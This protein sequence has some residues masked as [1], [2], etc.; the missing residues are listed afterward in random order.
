MAA[1]YSPFI[2]AY[3]HLEEFLTYRGYDK[4]F[5]A[6]RPSHVQDSDLNGQLTP[7]AVVK[8][9]SDKLGEWEILASRKNGN[10]K[11]EVAIVF[12]LNETGKYSK[13]AQDFR[14]LVSSSSQKVDAYGK[15]IGEAVIHTETIVLTPEDVSKKQHLQAA[16]K[17]LN[18]MPGNTL[19]CMYPFYIFLSNIPEVPCVPKHELI[20]AEMGELFL[21]LFFLTRQQ[22]PRIS[23]T[24]PPVVWLGGRPGDFVV[25]WRPSET[26]A[27]L[28]PVLRYVS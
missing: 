8:N 11:T 28:F 10:G 27:T 15:S 16:L 2:G 20:P 1:Y 4:I 24:D 13:Q 21:T 3:L 5:E 12:L 25:V 14:R 7:I 17:E 19:Y 23:V 26:A 6:L 9:I 18:R 22:L